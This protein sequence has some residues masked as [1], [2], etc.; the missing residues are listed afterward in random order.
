MTDNSD[1]LNLEEYAFTRL[2][3]VDDEPSDWHVN[4]R[5]LVAADGEDAPAMLE[6][7]IEGGPGGE[8]VSHALILQRA[9]ASAEWLV[10]IVNEHD[11]HAS[12]ERAVLAGPTAAEPDEVDGDIEVVSI[13]TDRDALPGE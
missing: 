11:D 6:R 8:G 4:K 5:L 12:L 10:L 7:V 3:G 13:A 1:L 2:R 9:D